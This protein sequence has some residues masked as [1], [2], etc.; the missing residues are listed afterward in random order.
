ANER[1]R[2]E[3]WRRPEEDDEEEETRLDRDAAG[4][5]HP[6]DDGRK[7]ARSAADNDVL[8][9][10]SLEPCRIDS[11]VKEDRKGKQRRREPAHE[12][13][14][15]SYREGGEYDAKR[16]RLAGRDVAPWN[17]TIRSAAHHRVNVGVVPHVER[18]RGTG[19]DRDA[20]KRSEADHRMDMS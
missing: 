6:A 10:R 4:R 8:R 1:Q 18:A 14:E 16:K 15:H 20:Q 7:G 17:W 2:P 5:R 9:R 11:N 13:A 12:Q 3:M 19:A